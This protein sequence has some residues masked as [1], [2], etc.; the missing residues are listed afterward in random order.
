MI[1]A[2]PSTHQRPPPENR[3]SRE[4]SQ[5]LG[6]PPCSPAPGPTTNSRTRSEHPSTRCT[7]SGRPSTWRACWRTASTP[8]GALLT[9]WHFRP[10]RRSWRLCATPSLPV[11]GTNTSSGTWP[12]GRNN[13]L[14]RCRPHPLGDR[15]ARYRG[16]KSLPSSTGKGLSLFPNGK[17]FPGQFLRRY[18]GAG[19]PAH[20]AGRPPERS[21][22]RPQ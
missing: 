20:P 17:G 10:V 7:A 1:R 22:Q 18:L 8:G 3:V 13:G 11:A 2:C 9:G 6:P 15:P 14:Y 5:G 12:T 19:G 16:K 4:P 21:K